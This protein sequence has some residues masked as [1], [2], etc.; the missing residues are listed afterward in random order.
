[1]TEN[2]RMRTRRGRSKKGD[3]ILDITCVIKETPEQT[4]ARTEKDGSESKAMIV[5]DSD[6]WKSVYIRIGEEEIV[7]RGEEVIKAIEN[8]IYGPYVLPTDVTYFAR[9]ATNN[10]VW[11]RIGG[12]I[13][14]Y[15]H[16]KTSE[17]LAE[18]TVQ[19]TG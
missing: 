9:F 18:E 11:G 2:W 16:P 1:M 13:F 8:A 10:N 14:C 4:K 17:E 6:L 3:Y 19:E 15:E 5:M 12:H 7:L